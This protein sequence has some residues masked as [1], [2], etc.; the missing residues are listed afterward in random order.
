LARLYFSKELPDE[1]I[2]ISYQ[3]KDIV[4]NAVAISKKDFCTAIL[5]Q[6]TT[7]KVYL[8]IDK[9]GIE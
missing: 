2:I 8:L 6:K 9:P 4:F 3:D 7:K 5:R 1:A